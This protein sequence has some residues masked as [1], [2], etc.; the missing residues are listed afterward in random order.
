M[1]LQGGD[2]VVQNTGFSVFSGAPGNFTPIEKSGMSPAFVKQ[3]I[4]TKIL[5]DNPYAT[6]AK[7]MPVVQTVAP[8]TTQVEPNT[9]PEIPNPNANAPAVTPPARTN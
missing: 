2:L 3:L 1:T 8:V 9:A 5:P 7:T 6:F 4:A